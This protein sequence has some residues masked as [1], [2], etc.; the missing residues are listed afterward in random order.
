[1]SHGLIVEPSSVEEGGEY[2]DLLRVEVATTTKNHN[3][4]TKSV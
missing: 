2:S 1:M 3:C 4:V